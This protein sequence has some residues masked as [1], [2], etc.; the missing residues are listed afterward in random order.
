M[1][2]LKQ[3]EKVFFLKKIKDINILKRGEEKI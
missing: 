3:K 1:S 2:I